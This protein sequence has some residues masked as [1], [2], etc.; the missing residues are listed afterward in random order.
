MLTA[1][2]QLPHCKYRLQSRHSWVLIRVM[3]SEQRKW[4]LIIIPEGSGECTNMV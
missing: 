3:G 2:Q 1:A 4:S